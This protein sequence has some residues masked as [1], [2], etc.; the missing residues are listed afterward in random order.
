MKKRKN[1]RNTEKLKK[2]L[3]V[4]CNNKKK[5]ETLKT[6]LNLTDEEV[7]IMLKQASFRE[8]ILEE[9]KLEGKLEGIKEVIKIML[10]N[11]MTVEQ[12]AKAISMSEDV[13]KSYI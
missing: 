1:I 7:T 12:I 11:G 8:E 2:L 5:T 13:I 4:I 10:S 3:D 6:L 9:G